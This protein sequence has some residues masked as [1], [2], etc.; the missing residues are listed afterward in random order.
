MRFECGPMK[1]ARKEL[2]VRRFRPASMTNQ[3]VT[4]TALGPRRGGYGASGA[5]KA[6]AI[7][8]RVTK[9]KGGSSQHSYV[10]P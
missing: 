10:V 2:P 8:R 3:V 7:P 1:R 5:S 9:V 6:E 4:R